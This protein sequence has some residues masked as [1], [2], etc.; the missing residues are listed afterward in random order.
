ME[1]K[2]YLQILRKNTKLFLAV[3]VIFAMVS[4]LYFNVIRP[5]SY[6]TSLMLNISR[7]G[8]QDTSE[9]KYDDFYRLQA[10]EKFAETV[11]EW[12]KD[13]RVVENIYSTAG[14][15]VAKLTLGQLS[16]NIKAEKLSSQIVSVK[17]SSADSRI[18]EKISEA[19]VKKIKEN[20]ESLNKNQKE[21]TWFEIVSGEPVVRKYEAGVFLS[22]LAP[23]FLGIF[24]GLWVILIKH[25]LE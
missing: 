12:L 9:Y 6:D 22:F 16:K 15:D 18:S 11:T 14:I 19:V 20:T 17:F 4:L 13:P 5:V 23:L 21:N 10:D 8:S 7:L 3:P 24:T 25:Y 1:L 2:E